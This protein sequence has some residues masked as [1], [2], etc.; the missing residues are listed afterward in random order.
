[1][2]EKTEVER[3]VREGRQQTEGWTETRQCAIEGTQ[4]EGLAASTEWILM[5]KNQTRF[6]GYTA[7]HNN[8]VMKQ[9]KTEVL[10]AGTEQI[11]VSKKQTR[12]RNY[13]AQQN[14]TIMKQHKTVSNYRPDC[15]TESRRQNEGAVK[16]EWRLGWGGGWWGS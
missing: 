8:T 7:Q 4:E 5:S 1:M 16:Q 12:F 15:F 3:E 13:T 11:L 6:H 9:C 2:R 14:N 10:A